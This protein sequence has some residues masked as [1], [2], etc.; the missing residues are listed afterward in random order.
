MTEPSTARLE[1]NIGRVLRAG[2][3]F[4]AALLAAG[5]VFEAAAPA[6]PAA[7]FL[8]AAGL[9]VL[10]ATPVARVVLSIVEFGAEGDWRFVA[11]GLTV[12]GVL[13]GSLLHA[14]S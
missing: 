6:S 8:L 5:L 3:I 4:S 13:L 14:I 9:I 12:L 7:G 11:I 1:R 2:A 10:M